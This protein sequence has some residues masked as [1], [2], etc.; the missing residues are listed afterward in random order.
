MRTGRHAMAEPISI[1]EISSIPEY[2]EVRVAMRR[3]IIALK[4]IRR[5]ALGS[6]ISVVFENRQTMLFQIHEMMRAEGITG[7]QALQAECDVYSALLP[8]GDDLSATL[9]VEIEPGRDIRSELKRLIGIDEHTS[10]R[11]GDESV[12]AT[13]EEGRSTEERLCTI[14][15]IRF[16]L[17]AAQ[18]EEFRDLSVP[19]SLEIHHRAYEAQAE[20]SEETRRS[21]IEDL[22]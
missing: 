5:V 1:S 13:V 6:K 20:L 17:T 3:A 14:L 18:I 10:L 11:I 12:P 9:F 15:Y 7:Q 4:K 8:N 2:E 22:K 19:A 16:P 21:L